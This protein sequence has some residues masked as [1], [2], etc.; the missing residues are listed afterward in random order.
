MIRSAAA[1]C[2]SGGRGGVQLANRPNANNVAIAVKAHFI[3]VFKPFTLARLFLV[4][5]YRLEPHNHHLVEQ[6]AA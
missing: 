3:L 4:V 1:A 5:S 6:E 2:A